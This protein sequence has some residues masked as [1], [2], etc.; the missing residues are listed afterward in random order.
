M[1]QNSEVLANR[2]GPRKRL[3]FP[4]GVLLLALAL[5][6]IVVLAARHLAIGLDD[7]FQ[8]D[9]LARSLAAGN[10]F[11]WYAPADAAQLAPYLNLDLSA[12]NL[13]PRGMLTTFRA[14]LYPGF[15]ALVYAVFGSGPDRFFHARLM[16]AGIGAILAPM[17]FQAGLQLLRAPSW[18]PDRARRASSI[19]A[20]AIAI[21]PGLVAFPLALATEN[22]FIPLVLGAVLLLLALAPMPPASKGAVPRRNRELVTAAASG[23]LLG[24]AALTRSVILPFCAAAVLW[25]LLSLRRP[26]LA[27]ACALTMLCVVAPWIVRNTRV[28][29]RLTGIETAMGYN[30]YLGYHPKS[31]GAFTFGPSLDLLSILDDQERDQAGVAAAVGFIRD[32]PARLPYLAL[33]R[34]GHFFDLEWRAVI[35]F[36]SNGL[37][38]ALPPAVVL[39][40][41]LLFSMPF[42]WVAASAALGAAT[43]PSGSSTALLAVFVEAYLLPHILILAEERF[44]LL[45]IPVFAVL[46]GAAWTAG[47]SG[48]SKSR[49]IR[50]AAVAVMALLIN[51]TVQLTQY[52]PTLIRLLG[53]DGY[54]LHLP[55]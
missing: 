48:L 29:G 23:A 5:R 16:Q 18:T 3:S 10:G 31:T 28:S 47:L 45:L 34:L 43:L 33:R 52:W 4:L 15:L 19:A 7:M 12:L 50:I 14:P 36:Y 24:L 54:R 2:T 44:H 40:I 26:L 37:V 21:Y 42:V 25:L 51:W 46:A 27:V 38:G 20:L 53:P 32:D 39:L 9:M 13:D 6:L 8:Y 41:L 1:Q 55:Y 22:L 35:Y 30:L 17:T 49:S 11:R